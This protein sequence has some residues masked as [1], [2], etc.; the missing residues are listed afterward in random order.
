M[1]PDTNVQRIRTLIHREHHSTVCLLAAELNMNRKTVRHILIEDFRMKKRYVKMVPK[2]FL[3]EQK[4]HQCQLL[5]CSDGKYRYFPIHENSEKIW[6]NFEK[7][8]EENG[9]IFKYVISGTF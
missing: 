8:L 5:K 2:N 7:I 9:K 3:E 4:L 6:G 1:R